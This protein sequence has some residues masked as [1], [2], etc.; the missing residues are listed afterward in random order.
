MCITFYVVGRSHG[1]EAKQFPGR[2]ID[3]YRPLFYIIVYPSIVLLPLSLI[4]GQKVL[5]K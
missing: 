2:H 1:Q 4:V 3:W 5:L